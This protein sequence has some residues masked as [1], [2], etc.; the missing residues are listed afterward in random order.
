MKVYKFN[1]NAISIKI[2][3]SLAHT[4]VILYKLTL[5]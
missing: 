1:Q 4:I 2:K 5:C 3:N